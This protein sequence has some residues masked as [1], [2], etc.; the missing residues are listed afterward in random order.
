MIARQEGK[1]FNQWA[2]FKII[3]NRFFLG[4]KALRNVLIEI[5]IKSL[6][7]F[8]ERILIAAH[9]ILGCFW[10]HEPIP[11]P[12][13]LFSAKWRRKFLGSQIESSQNLGQG[14]E[15]EHPTPLLLKL[16]LVFKKN[17]SPPRSPYCLVSFVVFNDLFG[18][19]NT[20]PHV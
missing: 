4:C 8:K 15:V 1:R 18:C 13:F 14:V 3:M 7:I 6:F 19:L 11:G 5:G 10:P 17:M 16:R 2:N 12:F 20:L 9:T